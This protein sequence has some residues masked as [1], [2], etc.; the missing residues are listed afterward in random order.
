M[1]DPKDTSP[2][3]TRTPLQL[4]A[5][6]LFDERQYK[7]CE[8]VALCELSQLKMTSNSTTAATATT[9]TITL[10]ILGDCAACT[11]RHRQANDYYR[12]A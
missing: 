1:S 10:E 9:A 4:Q 11:E 3:P 5:I 6:R 12:D 7:S 8:L 2:P